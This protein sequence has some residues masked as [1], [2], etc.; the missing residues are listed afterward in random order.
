M[1]EGRRTQA[2]VTGIWYYV[3]LEPD[4]RLETW[5]ADEHGEDVDHLGV[6]RTYLVPVLKDHYKLDDRAAERLK[7]LAYGVP[8]GR[9]DQTESEVRGRPGDWVFYHGQDFPSGLTEESERRKLMSAFGLSRL[10]A[11]A[12]DKI[13]FELSKHEQMVPEEKDQLGKILKV[14]IPY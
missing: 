14:A 4:W 3:Y 13:R 6:W 11:K 5:R 7:G 1:L 12:P 8:R 9:L 2:M 10:A